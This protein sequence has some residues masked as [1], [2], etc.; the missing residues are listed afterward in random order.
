MFV[1]W[2]TRLMLSVGL[3][4]TLSAWAAAA[5]WPQWRGPKFD[6]ISPE[7]GFE[8][9][10]KEP[11]PKVWDVEIGS[12][13]SGISVVQDK[14][15]TCGTRDK[16]QVLLCINA[17][18][19]KILWQTPIEKEYAERQ[20]GDGTR[21]TPT[22]V[23][24]KVYVQGGLGKV[25]CAD[26]ETGKEI[27]SRAFE[28]KPTWGYSGSILVDGDLAIVNGGDEKGAIVALNKKTGE[29]VWQI[30]T[31]PAGYATPY[32]FDFEGHH[33]VVGFLGK[34]ALVIDPKTG[35]EA[36]STP[37][38]TDWDVNAATPIF[39]EGCLF[40]TSGYKTG[41]GLFKLA[42]ADGKLTAQSAWD[43]QPN[44]VIM[45]KF[46][47]P[48]LYEGNL[49]VSDQKE[50]K[51]V[52]FKTGKQ[53]WREGGIKDS[54]VVIADGHLFVFTEGGELQIAK[55]SPEKYAPTAKVK[56][57]DGRCWTVPTLHDGCIYVRNFKVLACYK[58]TK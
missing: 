16:Q 8:T 26:A 40:L 53:T 42:L 33:Y 1:S 22:V 45:G 57:L 10:W 27:W 51:C 43:G 20:G 23:D 34:S 13:F 25:I 11:P 4:V 37:W 41:A 3:L 19:G 36:W 9:T 17:K 38:Q 28:P 52:E 55:A 12:A 31:G 29:P 30:G 48:V 39:H 54:T 18:D 35:Q 24:G 21:G 32:P 46:Q 2:R 49:Y 15:Y 58:L 56:L 50:L 47:T 44:K 5:D 14:L 7:K 6:G